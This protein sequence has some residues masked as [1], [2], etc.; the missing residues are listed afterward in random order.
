MKKLRGAVCILLCLAM[1]FGLCACGVSAQQAEDKDS[2]PEGTL[3]VVNTE[4]TYPLP[5]GTVVKSLARIDSSL[6][7]LGEKNGRSLLGLASYEISEDGKPSV[8]SAREISMAP[9]PFVEET[10]CFSVSAGGDGCFYL[11]AGSSA[12]GAPV[13]L[14]IQKYSAQGEYLDQMEIPDWEQMTV[15][16]FCAGNQ[17]EL[18]LTVDDK[19]YIYRWQ[20]G[21]LCPAQEGVTARSASACSE[22]IVLSAYRKTDPKH[23]LYLR[24]NSNTG[25]LHEL[26]LSDRDPNGDSGLTARR[27]NGSA[28]SCQG[29]AGEYL[30]GQGNSICQVDFDSDRLELLTEWDYD[31]F[32]GIGPF[33]RLSQ[34]AF[35]CVLDGTLVLVWPELVETQEASPVRVGVINDAV[36]NERVRKLSRMNTAGSP[37]VYETSVYT[38]AELDLFR[39]ELAAGSF[40]LIIFSNEINTDSTM[41]DD[42]YPYIDVDPELSREDFLPNLLESMSSGGELHQLWNSVYVHTMLAREDIVGDGYGLTVKDCEQLAEENDSVQSVFEN[43]RASQSAVWEDTLLSIAYLAEAAFV[44]KAEGTCNFDSEE[45]SDL[46]YLCANTRYTPYE[47]QRDWLLYTGQVKSADTLAESEALYGRCVYIGYPNGGGGIH[48]YALDNDYENSM[49]MAIPSNSRNKEGA[50]AF[51]RWT[52]SRSEQLKLA[53]KSSNGVPT[54]SM[55]VIFPVLREVTDLNTGER[56]TAQFYDLLERTKYAELS[57]DSTLRELIISSSQAYLA[58]EKSLE[59]TVDIIQSR[60]GTYMAEQYG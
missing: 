60:V 55:P 15:D 2:L 42:L 38:S 33:C 21:L 3:R 45:F 5:V 27:R 56:D 4:E 39:N 28:I 34:S 54:P 41:F 18:L 47:M 59:E 46:L 13:K 25:Q 20:E 23:A 36:S 14:V 7:L 44:D 1:S 31:V 50:W 32:S 53:N 22:G 35:A 58:G 26:P 24:V 12:E 30:I 52:L 9:L 11:L 10:I 43:H 8:S 40:D 37:Y 51:I 6:L 17:G 57:G 16:L 49:T 48:Y 29:L 19:I